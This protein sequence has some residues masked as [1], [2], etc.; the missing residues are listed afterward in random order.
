MLLE[1]I[2]NQLKESMKKR[3]SLKVETLRML[4]S[5]VSYYKIEKR[6][7]ELKD[8]DVLTVLSRQVKQHKESIESFEKGGREDLVEKEKAELAILESYMP[9]QASIE[10]IKKVILEVIEETGASSKKDFGK[11]MKPVVVKLKGQADGKV[12]SQV[13]GEEL[14]KL[15]Q[16]E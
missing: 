1:K 4:K 7:E 16:T 2:D 8:E 3:D 14:A 12:I 9:E 11:V 15:E 13:V 6:L 5:A 10:Q